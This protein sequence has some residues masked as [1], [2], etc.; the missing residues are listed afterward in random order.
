MS[1]RDNALK[2]IRKKYEALK[3]VFDERSQRQW[4]AAE[5]E[6]YG[7][8]GL[9]WVCEATGMSHNT[10]KKGA[11][12]IDAKENKKEERVGNKRIRQEGGGRKKLTDKNANLID[13][14]KRL[15]EP[16]TR[17][18]PL[19][20]LRWTNKSTYALSRELRNQGYTISAES[21]GTLLKGQGYRLQTN[22]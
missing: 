8:G 19:S 18:D 6:Q 21:V 16:A 10:V 2:Q 20:P 17:G 1:V 5:A 14:L 3:S 22:R 4:D 9:A 15:V 13:D 12:E 11:R 7:R